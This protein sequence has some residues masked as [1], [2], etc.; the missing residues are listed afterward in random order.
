M[1]LDVSNNSIR[2]GIDKFF[3][4]GMMPGPNTRIEIDNR[5]PHT[6]YHMTVI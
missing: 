4:F 1:G 2:P 3:V 5:G 6:W